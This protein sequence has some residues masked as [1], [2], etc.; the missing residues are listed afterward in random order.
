M[1][2]VLL[3]SKSGIGKFGVGG[4]GNQTSRGGSLQ[5]FPFIRSHIMI[6]KQIFWISWAVI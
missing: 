3:I 6:E 5:Y 2:S 4:E 1:T